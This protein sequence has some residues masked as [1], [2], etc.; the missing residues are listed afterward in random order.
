MIYE[1]SSQAPVRMTMQLVPRQ[2]K[3]TTPS[4]NNLR[5]PRACTFC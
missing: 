4:I 1:Q 2:M 3:N 5:T